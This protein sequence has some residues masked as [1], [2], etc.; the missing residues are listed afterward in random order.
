MTQ[1]LGLSNKH[2]LYQI[3][4]CRSKRSAVIA[5]LNHFLHKILKSYYLDTIMNFS[6]KDA[7]AL[8]FIYI[9]L[10][11]GGFAWDAFCSVQICS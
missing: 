5:R 2:L 7:K 8:S 3:R 4:F 11:L 10:R 9:S 1:E 6:R